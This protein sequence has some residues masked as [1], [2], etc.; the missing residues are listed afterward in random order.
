[1]SDTRY[2]I[3]VEYDPHASDRP[4]KAIV[5]G[6]ANFVETIERADNA[7]EAIVLARDWIRTE[8]S[9]HEPSRTIW[10]DELGRD[11]APPELGAAS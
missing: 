5:F 10:V 11:A 9:G 2:A 4:W 1:M 8:N 7:E 3:T 6:K